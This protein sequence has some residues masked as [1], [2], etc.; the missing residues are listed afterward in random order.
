MPTDRN[1]VIRGP[2]NGRVV[3][4]LG[5][6]DLL[7]WGPAD[8][9]ATLR[10]GDRLES[11]DSSDLSWADSA[12]ALIGLGGG[13]AGGDVCLMGRNL[14]RLRE[15]FG[16]QTVVDDFSLAV[17]KGEFISFLGP[18]GCGKTTTLQMI[19]GFLDPT[20]GA[21]DIATPG[22]VFPL[23]ARDGGVLVRAGHTEAAVDVARLAGLNPAG[24][25]CEIV[26]QKDVGSMAQT[27]ELRVFADEHDLALIS[28]ADLIAWRR[29]HEK[30]VVRVA[31]ARIPTRHG[32]F[33]AV[34][35]SSVY[36]DVEHR[37]PLEIIA[38]IE[39]MDAEIAKGLDEL[40]AMLK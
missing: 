21:A 2:F 11:Y 16:A 29:R 10:G 37:E 36:D 5:G 24:V 25:I 8:G 9:N 39:A 17:G 26:S 14:L 28:I 38:D 22:H 18:S 6:D 31:D 19:A 30:H 33:R 1:D 20:R 15:Q 40:K 12:R 3:D 32:D 35:Y 4:A 27:D 23:R 7:Y 34:G 13:A